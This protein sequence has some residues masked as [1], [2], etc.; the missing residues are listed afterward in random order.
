MIDDLIFDLQHD[1]NRSE[2]TINGT[3]YNKEELAN[4]IT[5]LQYQIEIVKDD[6]KVLEEFNDKQ[7]HNMNKI[8][9]KRY[10]Q[11]IIDNFD[12][13]SLELEKAIL[14]LQYNYEG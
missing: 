6:Y 3:N 12:I 9:S 11:N 13:S 4:E 10:S 14:E 5:E 2:I 1:E 7:Y 8:L